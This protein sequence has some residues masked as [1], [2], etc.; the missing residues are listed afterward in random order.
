[1]KL[2]IIVIG[3]IFSLISF[4][5]KAEEITPIPDTETSE[6]IIKLNP[7]QIIN[8]AKEFIKNKE[9]DSAKTLLLK[10]PFNVKELEIERLYLLSEI[11]TL[12]N[13]IDDAI[14]ILRFILD[15]QPNIS[16]IRFKLAQ[17]YML[18]KSWYR[19]DYHLRLAA[20]DETLPPP[21]K[22]EIAKYI[23]VARQ[24]KNW[25]IWFNIGAA[26]D[27]NINN[28]T[29]GEQCI[30]TMWGVLCNQLSDKEK[31]IGFNVSLG[32]SYEFLINDK[33]RLRNEAMLY[34]NTYN[35]KEYDDLYLSYNFGPKYV[36]RNGE[37]FA[38]PS[39]YRR[40][41]AH[42]PYSYAVGL[43]INTGYDFTR[44]LS[45]GLTLSYMPT[46]YDDYG[47]ILDGDTRGINARLSYM[48][49]AS[50]Y[51]IFRT[52]YEIENTKERIYSNTRNSY[53]IGF[54]IELPYG[55]TMYVEPSILYTNYDKERWFVKNLKFEEIKE[56]DITRK[57]SLSL[58]NR[59]LSFWGFS[60]TITYT[61]TDKN[62]NVWQHEYEK[63]A[64][65]MTLNQRF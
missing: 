6:K 60:P 19:A 5:I 35:K 47:E 25:N 43:K 21:V 55:F 31:A 46:R 30:M 27:D 24:N 51:L 62:S 28:A 26:P 39:A 37:I 11:A 9:Y 33:W 10:S 3:V 40:W 50:K 20:T 4:D 17:L 38:G 1:M 59:K 64:I 42:Q 7:I 18:Q 13:R 16:S 23:Y 36:W 58:S 61:Y 44:S 48:F 54:G 12:E 56:K 14:E 57:Y 32:G 29:G 52:G 49:D 65:E 41:L 8:L 22:Q 15:Y 2:F 63:S 34:S 53:A 45:G